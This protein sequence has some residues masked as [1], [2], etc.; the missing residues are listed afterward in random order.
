MISQ[1]VLAKRAT[2]KLIGLGFVA[3]DLIFICAY[4]AVAVLTSPE[5]YSSAA[6]CLGSRQVNYHINA[7]QYCSLPWGPFILSIL[8]W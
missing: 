6:A 7:T 8:G 5:N 1:V 2:S 3:W 4:I